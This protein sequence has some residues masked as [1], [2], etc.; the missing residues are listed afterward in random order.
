MPHRLVTFSTY[1]SE[2]G[3]VS[4]TAFAFGDIVT[5]LEIKGGHDVFAPHHETLVLEPLVTTKGEPD[6]LTKSSRNLHFH[7]GN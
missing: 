7:L 3:D 1:W 6:L 2:I 5:H 4:C